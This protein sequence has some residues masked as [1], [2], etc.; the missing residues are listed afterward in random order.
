MI[1]HGLVLISFVVVTSDG[2]VIG[3]IRFAFYRMCGS[4]APLVERSSNG[5]EGFYASNSWRR[6]HG[7][8]VCLVSTGAS[9]TQEDR[10]Y[11]HTAHD[12][13]DRLLRGTSSASVTVVE[14]V[15][16]TSWKLTQ[17]EPP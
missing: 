1:D 13:T 3:T 8:G 15:T 10:Q 9:P 11:G 14:A 7:L 2:A 4:E 5:T 17:E 12:Y 16:E 6:N